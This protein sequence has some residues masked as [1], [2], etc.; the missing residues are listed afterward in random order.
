LRLWVHEHY[1]ELYSILLGDFVM[2]YMLFADSVIDYQQR[3]D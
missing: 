3:S 1:D 2:G